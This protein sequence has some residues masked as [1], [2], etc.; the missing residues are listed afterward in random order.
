MTRSRA[1]AALCEAF[2][3]ALAEGDVL[4]LQ[5]LVSR[6]PPLGLHAFIRLVAAR[7]VTNWIFGHYLSIAPPVYAAASPGPRRRAGERETVQA[8]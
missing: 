5:G 8:A 6:V 7:P 1:R 3:R 2:I 4:A